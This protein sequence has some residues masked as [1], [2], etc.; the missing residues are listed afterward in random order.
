MKKIILAIFI[1]QSSYASDWFEETVKEDK[2]YKYYVGISDKQKSLSDAMAEAYQNAVTEA[3][4]DNFGFNQKI[5]ESYFQSISSTEFNSSSGLETEEINLRGIGPTK[6]SIQK[7]NDHYLVYREIRYKKSE[8]KKELARLL[9]IKKNPKITEYGNSKIDG[10]I[11]IHTIPTNA[12]ITLIPVERSLQTISGTSNALFHTP[13]GK[14]HIII[15]KDGYEDVSKENIIIS[16]ASELTF[17]LKPKTSIINIETNTPNPTF[18]VEGIKRRL[19]LALPISQKFQIRIEDPNYHSSTIDYKVEDKKF[20]SLNV[21]LI[22]KSSSFSIIST[23]TNSNVYIDN[24]FIGNTPITGQDIIPGAHTLK[25]THQ[26]YIEHT[27][28]LEVLPNQNSSPIHIKL[29]DDPYLNLS[30]GVGFDIGLLTSLPYKSSTNKI[31]TYI[32]FNYNRSINSWFWLRTDY[33]FSFHGNENK[34]SEE[35]GDY[36]SHQISIGP[37][38]QFSKNIYLKYQVGYGIFN[39]EF[40]KNQYHK[41]N[42]VF[43]T[44]SIG[45]QRTNLTKSKKGSFSYGI[46]LGIEKYHYIKSIDNLEPK[47]YGKI[48]GFLHLSF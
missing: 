41:G 43:S 36:S 12:Q 23:P 37:Q 16:S 46:D 10:K 8:I 17:N 34:S 39:H 22:P 33:T 19:P 48:G 42:G 45:L 1:L 30:K 7:K 2:D 31:N 18:Y 47:P 24:K 38:F 6:Q 28:T 40:E 4:K 9:K 32:G 44:V 5:T 15:L 3:V 20:T 14:Y 11:K 29:Q 27:Q 35:G 25:V 26:D 21:D 13:I